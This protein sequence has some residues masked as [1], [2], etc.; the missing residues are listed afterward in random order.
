[1]N[2][3]NTDDLF[4]DEYRA[5]MMCEYTHELS[6]LQ[7]LIKIADDCV[8]QKRTNN[9][10]SFEGICYIFARSIVDYAKM[11]YDNL[12]LG[13]FYATNMITR[14]IVEN[15]VCFDIILNDGKKELWKY[16]LVQSYK[17]SV[18]KPK[19]GMSD[20]SIEILKEMYTDLD[21][22][23]TFIEMRGEKKPYI[24][25]PYGWT[26]KI[27]RRFNFEGVCDLVNKNDYNDFK[28]MSTY[29][30]GTAIHLKISGMASMDHIM[31]MISSI[32]IG[33]YRLV[34]MY[35]WDCVDESFDVVTDEIESIIYDYF[36]EWND[37]EDEA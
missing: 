12:L 29:S 8:A 30:H 16:Y 32:Y 24:D 21:I 1:M 25:L 7:Q 27:N 9:T 5:V 37:A 19:G 23:S 3:I 2:W 34:T 28:M 17:N 11:A 36:D 33:L 20:K 15:N 22:E 4:C 6:L 13:H 18:T 31:N 26:Y 10:F 14:T 35:C